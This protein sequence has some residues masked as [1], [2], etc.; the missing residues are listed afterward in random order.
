MQ[1]QSIRASMHYQDIGLGFWGMIDEQGGHWLPQNC[2]EALQQEGLRIEAEIQV[3]KGGVSAMMWG[4][5]VKILNFE[6]L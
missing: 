4:K 3:L 2:P 1:K 5:T 6:Y